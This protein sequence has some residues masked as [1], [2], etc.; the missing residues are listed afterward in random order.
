M[1]DRKRKRPEA[2]MISLSAAE[3]KMIDREVLRAY[4]T[5]ASW[6]RTVLLRECDRLE[7]MENP[8]GEQQ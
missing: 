7:K 3:M 6:A 2:L 8:Q 1:A 5:R 4:A